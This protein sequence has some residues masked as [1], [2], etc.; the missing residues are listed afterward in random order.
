MGDAIEPPGT[1][2]P[3]ALPVAEAF[4]VLAVR[5]TRVAGG[6]PVAAVVLIDIETKG[7]A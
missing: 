6:Q 2:A 5:S 4:A 7:L 1:E 3:A